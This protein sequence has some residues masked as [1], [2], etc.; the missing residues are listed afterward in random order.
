MPQTIIRMTNIIWLQRVLGCRKGGNARQDH[1]I[2][3]IS[4]TALLCTD[5][6]MN[7]SKSNCKTLNT[8]EI[9]EGQGTWLYNGSSYG[10]TEPF[11]TGVVPCPSMDFDGIVLCD[12][13]PTP[14]RVKILLLWST[15]V[16][17]NTNN[18]L[19][20]FC[21]I[22]CKRLKGRSRRGCWIMS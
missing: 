17:T 1:P 21:E 10:V 11:W 14:L 12:I 20:F 16:D 9:F 19:Y 3:I 15:L 5:F 6:D 2:R 8:G 4:T 22:H 7:V 18:V 13:R